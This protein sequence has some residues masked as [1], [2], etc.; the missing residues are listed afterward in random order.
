MSVAPS[1]WTANFVLD[2]ERAEIVVEVTDRA[3]SFVSFKGTYAGVSGQIVDTLR[4]TANGESDIID[5]CNE[6]DALHLTHVDTLTPQQAA[7][8]EGVRMTLIML[9]G[10]RYGASGDLEDI[11][12]A[13]F[14]NSDDVIDS[15]DVVKRIEEIEGA[16]EA[17]G[18]DPEN[19]PEGSSAQDAA[20]ELKTLKALED[21]ASP[22]AP[23]WSHG[24]ALIRESYFTQYAEQL[25]EDIGAINKNA[26]WPLAHID[27]EAAAAALKIDYTEVDFDGVT[28]L[29]R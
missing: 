18:L 20:D 6:W 23:D 22:Y 21:E 7:M 27:W 9:N 17:A 19:L 4:A 12:D 24:E 8:L 26:E 3:P 16:F 29:I 14:S 11:D 2:N 13:D 15:R 28:Y 25:A 5:L 10:E 1:K